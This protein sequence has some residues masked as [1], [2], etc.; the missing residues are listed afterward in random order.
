MVVKINQV[1]EASPPWR[2][3][4]GLCGVLLSWQVRVLSHIAETA[5][6]HQNVRLAVF[7]CGH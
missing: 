2:A 6:L 7:S 3:P 5:E 1:G 4:T